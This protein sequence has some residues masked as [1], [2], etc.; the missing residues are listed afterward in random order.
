MPDPSAYTGPQWWQFLIGA[1]ILVAV[2]LLVMT[3]FRFVAEFERVIVFRL[4]KFA[5]VKGP[6]LV[7]VIPFLESVYESV[8]LRTITKN[9]KID[10]ITSDGVSLTVHAVVF[11]TVKNPQLAVLQVEDYD[12]AIDLAA[13][14]ALRNAIGAATLS[15][16]RS[17]R[18]ILDRDIQDHII[19]KAEAWGI[20]VGAVEINDVELPDE[21]RKSLTQGAQA[22]SEAAA[23]QNLAEAEVGIAAEFVKAAKVYES[24]SVA[25]D[26]RKM[27]LTAE[28]VRDSNT[29]T[30]IVPAP[31][32]DG[33]AKTIRS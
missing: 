15:T 30:I 20:L 17:N 21:L 10:A 32:L 19:P 33:L 29:H 1:A 13:Q 18:T 2:V 14:T 8:D 6:G 26:L 23:R 11:Y 12:D 7:I 31:W 24:D 22:L 3:T 4:G 28:A 25:L 5:G 9:L 27:N 16:V